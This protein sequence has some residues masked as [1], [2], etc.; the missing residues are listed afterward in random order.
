LQFNFSN[1]ADLGLLAI[2][3]GRAVGIDIEKLRP[4]PDAMCL[5]SL[6]FSA[7]ERAVLR[8][9]HVAE[10]DM[11]FLRCWTHKEAYIK[12]VGEGLSLRLDSFDVGFTPGEA[13]RLLDH[14]SNPSETARWKIEGFGPAAGYVG[15]LVA[16][17]HGW[18]RRQYEWCPEQ[19]DASRRFLFS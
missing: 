1:S 12:A 19:V 11:M 5:A 10:R 4:V 2:A 9:V 16:E 3:T 7:A 15:A 14:R 13:A 6:W 8:S 18:T 17:G